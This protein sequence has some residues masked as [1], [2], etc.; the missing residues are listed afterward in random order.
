MDGQGCTKG[1]ET[2]SVFQEI[3]WQVQAR[4]RGLVVLGLVLFSLGG[5]ARDRGLEPGTGSLGPDTST[6]GQD[7]RQAPR[8]SSIPPAGFGVDL[9]NHEVPR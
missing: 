4:R 1:F 3:G 2:L 5:C 7:M 6:I 9:V 8:G